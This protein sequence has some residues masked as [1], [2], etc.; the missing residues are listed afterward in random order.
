MWRVLGG[1]FKGK[2]GAVQFFTALGSTVETTHFEPSDFREAGNTVVNHVRHD[3]TVRSTGKPFSISANFTWT[4]NDQGQASHW[5]G[6]GDYSSLIA[7][8]QA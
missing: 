3:G 7:A 5:D 8:L 2:A 1:T 4:F 6:S